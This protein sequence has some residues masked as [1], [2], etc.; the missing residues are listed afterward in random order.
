MNRSIVVVGSV[1][2]DFV[3][4]VSRI[5]SPGETIPGDRFQTFHG[6][7]GAN[8]AVA[9]ARLGAD[10][11]MVARVGDDSFGNDLR[12]GLRAASVNTD[13]VRTIPGTASGVAMIAVDRLGQNSII[14]V[15][16]AN[17]EL[18]P[19]DLDRCLPR[20]QAAGLLLA[21]LE[22]P[23]ETVEALCSI[24]H[25]SQVPLMLDPAPARELS[26][27]MLR[28]VTYLT[29]NET[30]TAMLSGVGEAELAGGALVEAA[31]T[32][33]ARGPA[34]VLLKLGGRGV[35]LAGADGTRTLV[36]SFDVAVVDSTAAGDAFNGGLAT[37][38][39]RGLPL[40]A[41]TQYAV[42]VAALSVTRAG[43][44]AAMPDAEEVS[45]FLE[46]HPGEVPDA[47]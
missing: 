8:Q 40:R 29:P 31:E 21:Q 18:R 32:L 7:K 19:Q 35:F 25:R 30:E 23:M 24:A 4:T 1:N 41:A 26:P 28:S 42:A 43:A 5:P 44:Q 17:G 2:L 37:A 45:R 39:M 10:V 13:E 15:P 14:V 46:Q 36:P 34:N 38:L 33:L 6:G 20:L 9:A 11:A 3:C 16:G 12:E 22:V 47:R 27:K